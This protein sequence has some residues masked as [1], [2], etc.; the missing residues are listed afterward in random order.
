V[1]TS[2]WIIVF[3]PINSTG[4]WDEL[5]DGH[6]THVPTKNSSEE[7]KLKFEIKRTRKNGFQKDGKKMGKNKITRSFQSTFS[8]D[9]SHS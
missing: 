1:S 2:D 9:I 4:A 8:P 3:L 7:T 6:V 5:D